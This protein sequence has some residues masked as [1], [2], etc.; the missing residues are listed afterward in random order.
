MV[1]C[2]MFTPNI[3]YSNTVFCS[4]SRW[5]SIIYFIIHDYSYFIILL[6]IFFIILLFNLFYYFRF[7]IFYYLLLIVCYFLTLDFFYVLFSSK[8]I[9]NLLSFSGGMFISY[10]IPSVFS[11]CISVFDSFETF[12]FAV[13]LILWSYDLDTA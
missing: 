8:F 2:Y 13:L 11:I 12:C 4:K 5:L 1:L 10:G 6:I 3:I 9:N 7:F